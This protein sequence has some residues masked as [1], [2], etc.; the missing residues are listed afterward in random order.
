MKFFRFFSI[1][2]LKGQVLKF[3]F[4]VNKAENFPPAINF[5]KLLNTLRKN[6]QILT[7][8]RAHLRRK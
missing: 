5:G 2:L 3:F 1:F 8:T 7:L 6:L 4:K